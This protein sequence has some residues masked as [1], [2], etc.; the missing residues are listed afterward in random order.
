M[1]RGGLNP[2]EQRRLLAPGG[3]PAG[4]L[5][6]GGAVLLRRGRARAARAAGAAASF[7]GGTRAGVPSQGP[8][9]PCHGREAKLQMGFDGPEA[10]PG[11]GAGRSGSSPWAR[12]R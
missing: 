8:R 1:R 3:A 7:Y 12:P 9:R 5:L 2:G 4:R 10:G 6:R 11:W